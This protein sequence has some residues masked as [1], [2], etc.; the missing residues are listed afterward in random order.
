MN[1]TTS[2]TTASTFIEPY[3]ARLIHACHVLVA[4]ADAHLTPHG[5]N[6]R[7]R[8]EAAR[9]LLMDSGEITPIWSGQM[10]GMTADGPAAVIHEMHAAVAE[11]D[12]GTERWLAAQDLEW[13]FHTEVARTVVTLLLNSNLI[14]DWDILGDRFA[15]ATDHLLDLVAE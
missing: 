14:G 2:T 1:D 7:T 11:D 13:H 10:T 9:V 12:H 5:S 8:L 3:R 15:E 4:R 6:A